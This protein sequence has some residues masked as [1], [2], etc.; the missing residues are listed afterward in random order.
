MTV[1]ARHLPDLMDI[2]HRRRVGAQ[3][4]CLERVQISA[5]RQEQGLTLARRFQALE[6]Q[7]Q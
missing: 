1:A 6:Q 4:S 7:R 2:K 5:T 3:S